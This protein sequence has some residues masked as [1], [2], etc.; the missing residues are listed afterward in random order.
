MMIQA[1][2]TPYEQKDSLQR[3]REHGEE[4]DDD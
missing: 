1:Q 4:K 3:H 2:R